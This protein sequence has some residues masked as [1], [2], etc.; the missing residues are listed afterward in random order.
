MTKA[1]RVN[2]TDAERVSTTTKKEN[3]QFL[4]GNDALVRLPI[5][6]LRRDKA[7]GLR[8]K[9]FITGYPGSPMGG[10]D[11]ALH[12]AK[13]AQ[14]DIIHHPAQNEELAA[15]SLLGTQMLDNFEADDTD[16]VLG[17]WYGKG[18]GA[19]RSGDAFKHGNFAGTSKH[20]AVIIL[21]GED[22]E[23]KSSSVPYQQ[24]FGFE[25]SGI[26]VLYPGSVAEFL[27]F[28]LH[29][30]AMSRF[31]GCWVA[32]KLVAP[33][34][35]GGEVVDLDQLAVPVLPQGFKVEGRDFAKSTDFNFFPVVNVGTEAKLYNERHEAVLGY[36][37]A[38]DLNQIV[39]ISGTDKI[40]IIAAGKSFSDTRAALANLGLDTATRAKRGI[41]MAKVGLL[42]PL[43]ENFFRTF[44]E[45]LDLVIVIEEKRDFLERQV[46]K[47]IAGHCKAKIIGKRDLDGARLFPIE[48]GMDVDVVSDRLARVLEVGT[49]AP[50]GKAT[51]VPQLKPASAPRFANRTPNYCSGC[52]HNRSTRLGEG[53]IAWGAP[54]CHVFA[55]IMEQPEKRIEAMTQYGGEGLPWIGLSHY[56]T[57]KHMVQNVGDGS[58]Y[59]A[60]HQNIRYAVATDQT[61]TF[62]ILYNGVIANTGGQEYSD[63]NSIQNMC[64]KLEVDGVKKIVLAT[65]TPH[66]YRGTGLP[67]IVSL[68]GPDAIPARLLELEKTRGVTVLIYDGECANER[69]RRQ[70]RG[71]LA[72]PRTF[73]IVN[74]DVCEN[75]GDCG[76]KANC[77]SLQK[78]ETPF[79]RK[80]QIHQSSCNQD[81]ACIAGDCPSFISIHVDE[82]GGPGKVSP[83]ALPEV[84]PEPV[85]PNL[86]GPFSIYIPGVGGT[87]VLSLNAMLARAAVKDGLNVKTYDQSGAAQKWGAVL[88]SLILAKPE[89]EI[90]SNKVSHGQADLYL[91]LDMVAGT[92]PA[93]MAVC[94]PAR[95]VAA[96]NAEMLPTGEMARDVY[97]LPDQAGMQKHIKDAM[98]GDGYAA[99]PAL[100]IA[101]GLFGNYILSNM[102]I[103]GAAYQSGFLPISAE[104]IE[105]TI[106]TSATAPALN[107]LAFR[108]G[109]LAVNDPATM[110]DLMQRGPRTL[111][112]RTFEAEARVAP[113]VEDAVMRITAKLEIHSDETRALIIGFV[114][115]L[116]LYQNPGYAEKYLEQLMPL[117]R[118][119]QGTTGDTR[120][121]L[122]Q[123]AA[124]NLHKVMAYKDEYEVARLLTDPVFEDRMRRA[125]PGLKSYSYNLQPPA[126][127]WLVK[128]RKIAIGS[129]F[130]PVMVLLARMRGLRGTA[131]DLFGYNHGRRAERAAVE[132][133]ADVLSKCAAQLCPENVDTVTELLRLPENI[134]GYEELK[135]TSLDRA[136][137][138]AEEL[139]Q[140]I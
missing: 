3:R 78:V 116:I 35:D 33:L 94:D 4:T 73:T 79:G 103:V 132:W 125:F 115:D 122:L 96:V 106:K 5:E 43:D 60:S 72:K 45:G 11:M 81:T 38:N 21:S 108:A 25:H 49:P 57:K 1:D 2:Q 114:R 16:G 82:G 91:A 32:M 31:S 69:R 85:L 105:E 51:P 135:L 92:N 66:A 133:Y 77:M 52:P 95:T 36:A 22:H 56:T 134:R 15:T 138:R 67:A 13:I 41:R 112:D 86:E 124:R 18:P 84:F 111:A 37:R 58:Y 30:A 23:A 14:Y 61:M 24:E 28:G 83:P 9:G 70:K 120:Q 6:Q 101:E 48:G 53:Q 59:H 140:S 123:L 104:A 68:I 12:R 42:T 119:E 100:S 27:D 44:A 126:L 109:R 89:E 87:G 107:I 40:G 127:R 50:R 99:V 139:L 8:T 137:R 62:R 98:R 63:H 20:G 71:K 97:F 10:Y 65:K 102:I 54:G 74:E 129:W 93:N 29:A 130:R 136:K 76:Q 55:A 47:A 128:D 118:A 26:P 75:C 64:R 7:N 19:D 117:C 17:I 80:T 113:D 110:N 39:E 88:S 46:A 90:L 131:F 34:C 121:P